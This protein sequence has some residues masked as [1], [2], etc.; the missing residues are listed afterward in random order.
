MKKSIK[1]E[2][3][4]RMETSKVEILPDLFSE[5]YKCSKCGSVE[6]TEEQ[7]R[8]VLK[9]KEKTIK[10]MVSRKIGLIGGALVLRIPKS[11]KKE[12]NFR[13]GKEVRI[14]VEN[15]RMIVEAK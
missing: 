5:G 10:L 7:T 2:C 1:C 9:L 13:Q 3:G 4:G 6:F 14:L 11:V 12:L 15:N 8:K